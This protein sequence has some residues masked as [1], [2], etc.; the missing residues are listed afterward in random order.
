MNKVITYNLNQDFITNLADFIEKNFLKKGLDISRLSFVFGG[1]RPALFLKRALSRKIGTSFFPPTFFTIDE[2]VQYTLLKKIPFT[3]MPSMESW[4]II[5]TLARDIAPEIVKGREKFSQFLPWAREIAGFIDLLDLEDIPDDS[6]KNIEAAASIGYEI[7]ENINASLRNIIALRNAYHKMLHEKNSF[8]RGFI[9]RSAAKAVQEVS[10]E[11]FDRIFFCSLFY[12]QKTEQKL[13]R[14]IYDSGKAIFFF[15]GDEE[16]WPILKETSRNLSCSIKPDKKGKTD[17]TLQLHAAFD[18]HSQVCTVREILKDIPK[19]DST[20]IVLPD[21][22]SMLPLVSEIGS[23]AGEF[24]VSMGYPLKRSSL[25]SL[26]ELIVRAQKTRKGSDY[27]ARDYIA[28]LSQPLAK[29]LRILPDHSATRV[30]VHKVEEAL[31]GIENTS[32][33]G[34]LLVKLKDIENENGVFKAAAGT[35]KHMEIEA[36]T[37][38]LKRILKELHELLFTLWENISNFRDFASS[39]RTFLDALVKKSFIANYPLNRKIADRLYSLTDELQNSPFSG[40]NFEKEEL[41]KIFENMLEHEMV[42]FSGSPLRGLQILGTLE[43]RSLNFDNVI[44]MDANEGKLPKLRIHEPLIPHDVTMSFGLDRIGREEEIQRYLFTRMVSSA[45]NVHLVY[46]ENRE[47]ERSRF[48]EELIWQEQK[49]EK[50]LDVVPIPQVN[51][52][53]KVLPDKTGVD[54]TGKIVDCLREHIY[55]ATSVDTYI[56]CP[57]RF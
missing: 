42:A 36:G 26:F 8:S 11:E 28:G 25:H 48:V 1:K 50:N 38:D 16:N 49:K 37:E 4:H 30:L 6:L 19:H 12:I 57:L 33:S 20:V 7:P 23:S 9:Y 27:Y 31:L 41:F 55:S 13:I 51:F 56:N 15:Q 10:F 18:K 52:S 39:L 44:V 21:A 40:E 54:K 34:S 3:N 29:N 22:E 5:Y 46:E 32:L 35:L 17:C 2:F 47:K 43:T 14:H 53:V 45:K 24:N